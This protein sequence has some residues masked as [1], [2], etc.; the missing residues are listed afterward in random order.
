MS[1]GPRSVR[2]TKRTALVPLVGVTKLKKNV[3]SGFRLPSLAM[4]Q[5]RPFLDVSRR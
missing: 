1:W 4:V 2:R 3:S 5:A